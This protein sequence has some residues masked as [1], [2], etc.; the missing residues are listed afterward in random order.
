MFT[1]FYNDMLFAAALSLSCYTQW[2]KALIN[3]FVSLY[4]LFRV[5][6]LLSVCRRQFWIFGKGIGGERDA[7][8][9]TDRTNEQKQKLKPKT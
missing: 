9:A 1:D 4:T 3:L 8:N 7:E 2:K 6:M 5:S